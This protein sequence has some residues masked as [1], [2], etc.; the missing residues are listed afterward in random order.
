L[1]SNP[2]AVATGFDFNELSFLTNA[3]KSVLWGKMVV[4]I[5]I[6]ICVWP[7]LKDKIN[8]WLRT[9]FHILAGWACLI[10]VITCP[11]TKKA[12]P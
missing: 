1:K 5:E 11:W 10:L 6:N 12:H 4:V 8:G 9:V 7:S 2:K 3:V